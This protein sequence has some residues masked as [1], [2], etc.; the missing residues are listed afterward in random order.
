MKTF[1]HES[2][3]ARVSIVIIFL[4]LIRTIL[5]P[6]IHHLPCDKMLPLLICALI[7][8]ISCLVLTILSF[9]SKSKSI[10]MISLLTIITLVILKSVL[11][12]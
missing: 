11:K 2:I 6:I 10:V 7:T 1:R 12:I 4:A 8:S 5:E 3:V 9:F